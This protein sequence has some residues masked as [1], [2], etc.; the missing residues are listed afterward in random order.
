MMRN[1]QNLPAS[2]RFKVGLRENNFNNSYNIATS[3]K[4]IIPSRRDKFP[5]KLFTKE[6][7][8]LPVFERNF[9]MLFR[10]DGGYQ[11]Y[12]SHRRGIK[13]YDNENKMYWMSSSIDL[14]H[15]EIP[16]KQF[17]SPDKSYGYLRQHDTLLPDSKR[18][19]VANLNE[20]SSSRRRRHIRN[21]SYG[22]TLDAYRQSKHLQESGMDS[23]GKSKSQ[24]RIVSQSKSF[25][26]LPNYFNRTN[27]DPILK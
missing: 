11:R 15:L 10:R 12:K 27:V 4:E 17:I 9:N 8:K 14:S 25:Q 7:I 16:K 3:L 18:S 23:L 6:K 21:E 24:S 13:T 26:K 19:N 2:K 22:A 5:N 1:N 20:L